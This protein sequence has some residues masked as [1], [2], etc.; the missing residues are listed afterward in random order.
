[1]MKRKTHR[2]W[3]L[4]LAILLVFGVFPLG[5]LAVGQVEYA[6]H[7]E[8]VALDALL[9]EPEPVQ[10][11]PQVEI[12]PRNETVPERWGQVDERVFFDENRYPEMVRVTRDG[13]SDEELAVLRHT[14]ATPIGLQ[15]FEADWS[16]DPNEIIEV[17][18][19]FVTPPA[20]ALRLLHEEERPHV[21]LAEHVFE[22]QALAAH[23]AFREQL[24]PLTRGRTGTTE[25]FSEHHSLFNGV[26]MRVPQ[27]MVESI[28]QLPEV[29]SVMPNVEVAIELPASTEDEFGS[30]DFMREAVKLFNVD[31]IHNMLGFT[32]Q[33]I[34]VAVLDTG[35]DY[36]HPRFQPYQDPETGRIRGWNYMYD[37][38]DIMDAH[39]H[40]THVS[41]SV[42]ALAPDVEL[43]HFQVMDT[44]G[45]ATLGSVVSG[46][47]A[48]HQHVD[49]MNLSLGQWGTDHPFFP[50]S[51]AVNLAMLDG[52]VVIVAAGN[53][54]P[55]ASSLRSPGAACLA[56]SVASGTLGGRNDFGDT[57]SIWS[58]QGPV[59]RIRHIKPDITAPGEGIVSTFLNGSYEVASGTSMAAPHIAGVAALLLEAFP[60]AAPYEIKARMMNTARPLADLEDPT[61]F[62]TGA[63][64]VDPIRALTHEAFATVRH[65]IPWLDGEER[66]WRQET[67]ASLSFGRVVGQS[68]SDPMTVTIH[69]PGSGTWTHE[70]QFNDHHE[71]VS[72]ELAN[73][74]TN[75]ITHTYT[76]Q[77]HA[78][79]PGVFAEG[80][81]V[82]INGS[83]RIT[84]PFAV[85][86]E[87][88]W[89]DIRIDPHHPWG[90]LDYDFFRAVVGYDTV[91]QHRFR[92]TNAGNQPTGE[93]SVT[94]SGLDPDAFAID[95]VSVPSLGLFDE[96][97]VTVAPQLGL[98]VG[99]Y[100]ATVTVSV[101]DGGSQSFDVR[102]Q[103]DAYAVHGIELEFNQWMSEP[104]QYGSSYVWSR[105]SRV[106]NTGNVPTGELSVSL[107]GADAD[108]FLVMADET[109][110]EIDTISNMESGRYFEF[111]VRPH[112]GLA[113]GTYTATVVISGEHVP[114]QL[115]DV[116]FTVTPRQLESDFV[117]S[118]ELDIEAELDF[119]IAPLGYQS[120]RILR[121][122]VTN[123]G[124][125][126]ADNLEVQ[127]SGENPESFWWEGFWGDIWTSFWGDTWGFPPEATVYFGIRA[128]P[129]LPAGIHTAT[130]TLSNEDGIY[131]TFDVRFV[132][133]TVDNIPI[134]LDTALN[135]DLGTMP[136]GYRLA[137]GYEW[138]AVPGSERWIYAFTDHATQ[139]HI[140]NTG[141]K[142]TEHLTVAIEGLYTESFNLY[143]H[144][145]ADVPVGQEWSFPL[146]PSESNSLWIRPAH[147]LSAGIYETTITV[148]DVNGMLLDSFDVR[149]TV[150]ERVYSIEI[151]PIADHDFGTGIGERATTHW[152]R[153]KNTGN[154]LTGDIAV[155]LTGENPES[156]RVSRT[157]IPSLVVVGNEEWW[158]G[159]D[160]EA[161]FVVAPRSGLV[162]GEHS[163]TVTISG[164]NIA[165][166]SFNVRFWADQRTHGIELGPDASHD[167]G[168]V[169]TGYVFEDWWDRTYG[170][171]IR[172]TGD[173]PTGP[174]VVAL[175]G[176]NAESFSLYRQE[177]M[178]SGQ[179]L[180]VSNVNPGNTDVIWIRPILGLPVG[181]H[182]ATVV[183]S[184]ESIVPQ[185]FDVR[186]TVVPAPTFGISLLPAG[187]HTFTS[188]HQTHH[189]VVS[190]TG[191]QPTGAL[192]V[193]L[194]GANPDSFQLDAT[195]LPSIP[196]G[197]ETRSFSVTPRRGLAVGAHTAT[198]SVSDAENGITQSFTVSFMVQSETVQPGRVWSI[199]LTPAGDYVF[200]ETIAGQDTAVAHHV[201]VSNTG[202]QPTGHLGVVVSN[203]SFRLNTSML[204]SIPVGT[205]TRSF[206]VTPRRGLAVG[207]HTATVSVWNAVDGI[208]ET[209]TVSIT[210]T[211]PP[212]VEPE[213]IAHVAYM[214]GN[215]QGYFEPTNS[216]TRAQVAAILARTMIPDFEARTLPEGRDSFDV[217]D[218]VAS[219]N[220]FYYYVA[221]AYD[222]G[223]VTG[224]G[225]GR[226]LPNQPI[227]REQ[228]AAMLAR[229]IEYAE[230]AGAMLFPDAG[231]I[232]GWAVNY[233]YTVYSEGWMVGDTAG[234]F[235]PA[236]DIMRAEV[237]TA[238]NR[239]LGR[240]D[241]RS[242]L[243]AVPEVEGLDNAQAF[244]DVAEHNWFFAPVLAAANDHDLTKDAEGNINW[245]YIHAR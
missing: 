75:G 17:A 103:V 121:V 6:E 146:Q 152:V 151:T 228:L 173:A 117:F 83:Q 183:V 220:W 49:V 63:G 119:G 125:Y 239:I 29:F 187:D 139:M 160:S 81:V 89:R 231:A 209:F 123:T 90:Y 5:S 116:S 133:E 233:V 52:T 169:E 31:M 144:R 15:G 193:A 218:D 12:I 236:A 155:T 56:I 73:A 64:F 9:V 93:I 145:D 54:G 180:T 158:D 195:S 47:E 36:T 72:L 16:N 30:D 120:D 135:R 196:V 126:W 57:I 65:D 40:G 101:S 207:T 197:T 149:F 157:F 201:T 18:V 162:S 176:E 172:N 32:G 226:F 245:K 213:R 200:P 1:M 190:N 161:F 192:L 115:L 107:I 94:L 34:R 198:V 28:A 179:E 24:Q 130:V 43:W 77:A 191:N 60:T 11:Q 205:E 80:N 39:G 165:P 227:T 27:H 234:N 88:P 45:F 163:A 171:N 215:P 58:S 223:L 167:F 134:L 114:T 46:I 95:K 100:E 71:W 208:M 96:T 118:I 184:G 3:S 216:I 10:E 174:L 159:I 105:R 85:I 8:G 221:W 22:G 230:E 51:V 50:W 140:T 68:V 61:V 235:R 168:T 242:T 38:D 7:Y 189:L 82:F 178:P 97:F 188:E 225:R 112:F 69:N 148:R 156:F 186:F 4:F 109:H 2:I 26:F 202:N 241:S 21:R 138:I 185:S 211:E 78:E 98:G 110:E 204:M 238:V 41:G 108:S 237:A 79:W 92:V 25:I 20:V 164:E 23:D 154:V 111:S 129:N 132:V 62:A 91:G 219:N 210:V 44:G 131:E 203:D 33:G 182:T 104:V 214:F 124:N 66:T 212:P 137:W 127:L 99:V 199:R 102:F 74:N 244:P 141:E 232:G 153:V 243:E 42:I 87:E 217:F 206:S 48:A 122:G 136:E 37:T 67:M 175:V 194:G 229:T 222:A 240:V 113:I 106:S 147:G 76:F 14:L 224:D 170:I 55:N 35:I 13:R 86:F 143:L 19:Q 53:E 142:S 128:K 177:A 181:T 70:V 150:V 84:L 59:S 166:Q